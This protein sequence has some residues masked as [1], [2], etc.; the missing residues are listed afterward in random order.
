[1]KT[2][3]KSLVSAAPFSDPLNEAGI[4]PAAQ[5]RKESRQPSLEKGRLS[6]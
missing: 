1:M 5:K 2:A 4:A 6:A 3:P